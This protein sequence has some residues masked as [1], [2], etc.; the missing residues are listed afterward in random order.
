MPNVDV[1]WMDDTK[2][3]TIGWHVYNA[4]DEPILL[5]EDS[6]K[7]YVLEGSHEIV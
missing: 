4:E 5:V 6:C 1:K 3:R 2:N 7:P